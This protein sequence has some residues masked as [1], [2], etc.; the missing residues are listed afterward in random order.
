MKTQW[1]NRQV[2]KKSILVTSVS[3]NELVLYREME[4]GTSFSKK[5]KKNLVSLPSI[6]Y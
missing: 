4:H 6:N 2:L 1:G 3:F 5:K